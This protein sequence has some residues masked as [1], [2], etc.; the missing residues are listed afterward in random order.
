MFRPIDRSRMESA[1]D[2]ILRNRS[3]RVA[4]SLRHGV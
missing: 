4:L 2:E 3:N 1:L